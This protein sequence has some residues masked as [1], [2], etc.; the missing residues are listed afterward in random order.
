MSIL[1]A[2]QRLLA[3]Y[4]LSDIHT[5]ADIQEFGAIGE[6]Y[7]V[8]CLIIEGTVRVQSRIG[9]TAT[10]LFPLLGAPFSSWRP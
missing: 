7:I 5:A 8:F 1:K 3:P 6:G 2:G 9:F 10:F 4:Q